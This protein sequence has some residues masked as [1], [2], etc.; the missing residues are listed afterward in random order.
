MSQKEKIGKINAEL[1]KLF[2]K[3]KIA[4]D[5]GNNWELMVAVI[6]SAQCTDKKVNQVTPALFKKYSTVADYA[7]ADLLEFQKDIKSIGLFRA[8]AK[9]I[10]ESAKILVT[11]H[12]GEIPKTM[13]EMLELNGIGRKSA[14]IILWNA[15][16]IITGI[17]VDT[18][19]I[20][21][22]NLLG[23]TK[24]KNP[25]KIEKDLME[26]LPKKEWVQ[27][28]YRLIDYGRKYC[29]AR[30]RHL[31]CPLKKFIL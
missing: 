13:D 19:V 14:N 12:N 8:K 5:Y 31:E 26:I 16:G 20:R 6:L 21:L 9:N 7:K 2:P 28:P 1:K 3:S 4:L 29:T 11:K 25:E 18:H 30:C 17:P 23:L 15:Y 22:S 24:H 10:L 27:F